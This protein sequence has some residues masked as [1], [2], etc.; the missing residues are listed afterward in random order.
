MHVDKIRRRRIARPHVEEIRRCSWAFRSLR[1]RNHL[2]AFASQ[3]AKHPLSKTCYAAEHSPYSPLR[4]KPT[5]LLHLAVPGQHIV[6]R[7][8]Q[9]KQQAGVHEPNAPRACFGTEARQP[10]C[11]KPTKPTDK[12]HVQQQAREPDEQKRGGHLA[13]IDDGDALVIALQ[14]IRSPDKE[15]Q[16][17]P[18]NDDDDPDRQT[19]HEHKADDAAAHEDSVHRR[20][21]QLP[22][23]RHAVRAPCKLAVDPIGASRQREHERGEQIVAVEQQHHVHRHHAQPDEGYNVGNGEDSVSDCFG[24]LR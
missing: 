4:F 7:G 22:E 5:S 17:A 2:Y 9:A 3:D 24:F 15:H 19:A 14:Q 12:G 11:F 20:V 23:L 16:I 6:Q 13:G 8:E 18:Q 1:E 10:G 21:E